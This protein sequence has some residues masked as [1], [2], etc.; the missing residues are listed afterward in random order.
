MSSDCGRAMPDAE[1]EQSSGREHR[2]VDGKGLIN[3][4]YKTNKI[5]S[6]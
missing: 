4:I 5:I 2:G 1:S 3:L 6:K